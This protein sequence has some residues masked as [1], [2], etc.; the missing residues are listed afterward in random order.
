MVTSASAFTRYTD[1]DRDPAPTC[2]GMDRDAA[3]ARYYP[4]AEYFARRFL[5]RGEPL[6]DLVQ[7]ASI[8]LL[9]A[10]ERFD[11]D[12]GVEFPTFAAPTIIGELKRYFRDAGWPVRVPRRLQELA[13]RVRLS[14]T[15]L[16]Q[17]L[18]RSPTAQE[19]AA[20][21][22]LTL[23]EVLD[24]M[25]AGYANRPLSIDVPLTADGAEPSSWLGERDPRYETADAWACLG[26]L[27][28]ELPRREQRLLFMR[29]FEDR[30][31]G[32]IATELGMSQMHVSRL[33]NR[34]LSRLRTALD[35]DG[36]DSRETA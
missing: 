16:Y 31:Q 2:D 8:G 18:G 19:I 3:L 28:R 22:A 33:L 5:G 29:F 23:D 36:A 17:E 25:E 11:P 1:G 24:G 13:F 9:K 34:T 21:A 7:V 26:P 6:D 10:I 14:S 12:R 30:T 20:K 15:D 4:L 27:V 35:A 32:D